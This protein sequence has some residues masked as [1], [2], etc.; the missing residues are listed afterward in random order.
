MNGVP[1]FV[2]GNLMWSSLGTTWVTWSLEAA[3]YAYATHRQKFDVRNRTKATL[4]A[5]GREAVIMSICEPVEVDEIA[6]AM[7][8]GVGARR[9]DDWDAHVAD[10][11]AMLQDVPLYRRR[12]YLSVVLPVESL[13]SAFR[14][15]VSGFAGAFGVPPLPIG[16]EA[17]RQAKVAAKRIEKTLEM[18][19]SRGA[20]GNVG[21]RQV[22]EEELL[23]LFDRPVRRGIDEPAAPT[24]QRVGEASAGGVARSVRLE[25]AL[26]TEAGT[27][28]DRQG[29]PK[30]ARKFLRVDTDRGA[31]YQT[32]LALSTMPA[33]FA[34]PGSEWLFGVEHL[35][36]PID[37]TMRIRTRSN[38]EA[39]RKIKRKKNEL[40]YQDGEYGAAGTPSS[41][42]WAIDDLEHQQA[43][44]EANPVQPE[45]EVA[46]YFVTWSPSLDELDQQVVQLRNVY[47]SQQYPLHAPAGGQ[48]KIF[49]AMQPGT[50][51]PGWPF[52]YQ[53]IL[54]PEAL[55]TSVPFAGVDVGDPRGL[56]L[57]ENLD[58]GTVRLAM[59]DPAYGPSGESPLGAKSG[60]LGILGDLGSGKS[61]LAKR[62]CHGTIARGGQI[63]VLDRTP[64]GEW[65]QF[66]A[67]LPGHPQ[68]IQVA[69]GAGVSLDPFRVFGVR[70]GLSIAI[71]TLGMLARVGPAEPEGVAVAEACRSVA[72]TSQPTLKG[73]VA[74]LEQRGATDSAAMAVLRRLRAF[75]H[76]ALALLLFGDGQP[77][78]LSD[79][80]YIVFHAP[81][82]DLPTP[83]EWEREHL[84]RMMQPRKVVSQALLYLVTE[85]ARYISFSD[86]T[87]FSAVILE[88]AWAV[89][90]NT[91]G[92]RVAK[93]LIK[94]GRKHNAALWLISQNPHDF[95]TDEL[96]AHLGARFL[97]RQADRNAARRSLELFGMDATEA[98]VDLV[99]T[100]LREGD[101][102]YRDLAGR[103]GLVHV[104]QSVKVLHDAARTD[105]R[106]AS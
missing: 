13:T 89:L 27:A 63:V 12:L 6:D 44:L 96:S 46:T 5:L 50:R 16:A 31:A 68:T 2:A 10:T 7:A 37:W 32:M 14:L 52:D 87:R 105:Q 58:S 48:L 55:A 56:V 104:L 38:E 62:L 69:E 93:E 17:V 21:M 61:Y 94:D 81:N 49:E 24:P 106:L 75:E 35:A 78:D 80:D 4:L 33:H 1:Q 45:M 29:R 18:S 47:E 103:T 9:H 100:D 51:V 60:S 19:F 102:L 53:Q 42:Q 15:G 71:A 90:G 97:F 25:A 92:V 70:D 26:L 43:A 84:A 39:R 67:A 36:F 64:M 95:P 85:T 22:A 41:V 79:A 30:L 11:K 59:F 76:E 77:L 66:G 57:G 86:L 72:E 82:L 65:V 34:F 23:W 99:T 8:R 73:V 98:T 28:H 20:D 74:E 40:G 101:C 83:E 88:E 3:N 54:L 91:N